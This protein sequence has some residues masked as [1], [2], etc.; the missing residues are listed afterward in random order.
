MPAAPLPKT[1]AERL[2]ALRSYNVLDTSEEAAFDEIVALAAR[3]TNTP[4]SLVSLIDENRQWF[5]AHAGLEARETPRDQAFCAHA[6]LD[7][8]TPLVVPDARQDPRFADNPL[9]TG[10]PGIRFYAG[11]PLVNPEGHALGTLCVI[12]S[13]PREFSA[14]EQNSLVTLAH[15]VGTTLELRRA[16]IEIRRLAA[17][18]ATT[19]LHNQTEFLRAADAAIAR[20][21]RNGEI[22][23]VAYLDLK[24]PEE[25][26]PGEHTRLL[27]HVGAILSAS[28]ATVD[29]AARLGGNEFAALTHGGGDAGYAWASQLHKQF[30]SDPLLVDLH[31]SVAIGAATFHAPPRDALGALA[32]AE[33]LLRR[34]KAGA[35]HFMH[36]NK[37][38]CPA[39]ALLPE[40][41]AISAAA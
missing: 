7:P 31:T 32:A 12:D 20:H 34:A 18:D 9:V 26:A 27:R 19:G 11:V 23:T 39:L 36:E 5:K 15:T 3:L 4:I 21:H 28:L 40:P 24:V 17:T 38:A 33:T 13:K 6:I 37:G 25:T 30:A 14:D 41:A 29:F 8:N 22:F 2:A 1:E 16:M 35:S 10:G